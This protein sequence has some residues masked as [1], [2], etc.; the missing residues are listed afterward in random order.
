[1]ESGRPAFFKSVEDL[2]KHIQDYFA[3]C[4][5]EVMYDANG[6]IMTTSNGMPIIQYHPPTIS[7]LALHLGFASR[8]SIYDY[9]NR[10]DQFSYTIKRARLLCE[11]WV[12]TNTLAG[13]VAP[14]AGIFALKNYGWRDDKGLDITSG[15]DKLPAKIEIIKGE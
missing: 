7:G 15:G 14:A 11:N 12:E 6:K 4:I 2:E 13:N 3:E 10:N 9:E 8:Q 1:M 5:P